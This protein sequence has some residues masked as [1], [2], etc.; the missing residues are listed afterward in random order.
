MF[1]CIFCLLAASS[2]RISWADRGTGASRWGVATANP[3]W[4]CR[5]G[6]PPRLG[7]GDRLLSTGTTKPEMV[8]AFG[9]REPIASHADPLSSQGVPELCGTRSLHQRDQSV[10]L[11]AISMV[12]ACLFC[13][14]P[15]CRELV[16]HRLRYL[17]ISATVL[18]GIFV[19][20]AVLILILQSNRPEPPVKCSFSNTFV[21]NMV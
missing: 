7:T 3:Q 13:E 1:L 19:R 8:Q 18:L 6:F 12:R 10:S 9:Q 15:A 20:S 16:C 14:R 5:L 2:L 17:L 11:V 4:L 21:S